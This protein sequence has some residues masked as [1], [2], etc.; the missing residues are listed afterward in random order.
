MAGKI[1]E[2]ML[3]QAAVK[4]AEAL[5][6]AAKQKADGQPPSNPKGVLSC[7]AILVAIG[8]FISIG[9]IAVGKLTGDGPDGTAETREAAL[10]NEIDDNE[11][12]VMCK[13]YAEASAKFDYEW[14]GLFSTPNK[15]G[16][17]RKVK[18]GGDVTV[19][20]Y[21]DGLKLQNGFG[22]WSR[23]SFICELSTKNKTV[24]GFQIF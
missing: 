4:S 15:K 12:L 2:E 8:F 10:L 14:E 24:T 23:H 13:Y 17:D 11:A 9:Y 3:R 1:Y 20:V 5:E 6:N 7:L 16:V 22:A 21:A 18:A 19:T